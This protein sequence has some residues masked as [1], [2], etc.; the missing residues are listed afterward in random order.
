MHTRILS[1]DPL[2]PDPAVLQQA[3]EYLRAGRL[4]AFPTETVYGLGADALSAQA[5]AR[6]F[7]AKG[8]PASDPLIVHLAD[9]HALELVTTAR[10][11]MITALAER[12]WPGP[13]TLVLPKHPR[14]PP[15]ITAGGATVAV[16][17]PAHPVALGLI[18]SAG[19]PVAAPSANRFMRPSPTTARH[20]LDDLDGRIDLLLD[21]G[22]TPIGVEST[23]LDLTSAVPTILRPGG[24]PFEALRE[25]LPDVLVAPR[26]LA[27]TL[28]Q[29]ALPAPG[30]LLRHYAP[31][32]AM[33]LFLGDS[34]AVL[35]RIHTEAQRHL[36]AGQRVGVLI[37]EEDRPSFADLAVRIATPGPAHDPQQVAAGLFEALRSFDSANLDLILARG[38]SLQGL[39]LAVQDRLIRAAEGRVVYCRESE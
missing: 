2:H 5:A 14:V 22:A 27:D 19:L 17:V 3:A 10:S 35:Q 18:R 25:L 34:A 1:I 29:A 12:F 7:E 28:P 26:Y 31:E 8:R 39:G 13:L 20:V 32:A 23:V 37:A 16:R 15:E 11:K 36:E 33:T 6:I 9:L 4:V 30:Q 24:V 21:G 38:F